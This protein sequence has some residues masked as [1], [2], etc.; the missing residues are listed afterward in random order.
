VEAD[1]LIM[2]ATYGAP[3][4]NFP[5]RNSIYER[6]LDAANRMVEEG[7]TPVFHAYS[8]GKSQEAIALLQRGGFNVISGNQSIDKVCSVYEHHGVTLKHFTLK[9]PN[10]TGILKEGAVIVSSSLKHTIFS[11]RKHL[12]EKAVEQLEKRSES[13]NLSGWSIGKFAERGF[14]L[15]AHSDFNGLLSFAREVSPRVA[16][17]FTNNAG[18]FSK[19][20]SDIGI[21]AV[22]LE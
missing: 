18:I 8:L 12:D 20:L 3:P 4:W 14:P 5:D 16:Y 1:V 15:S 22:P 13:Y 10:I 6:I 21:N 2:E 17:V 9:S 19:H 11:A 7:R